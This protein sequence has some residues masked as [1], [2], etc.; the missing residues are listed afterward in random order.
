MSF[1]CNNFFCGLEFYFITKTLVKAQHKILVERIRTF[2]GIVSKNLSENTTHIICPR[3][4]TYKTA[5][6]A[7]NI[8]M[9][10]K[11]TVP[12]QFVNID[13]LPACIAQKKLVP[14]TDFEV[15]S[16]F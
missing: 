11:D 9:R 14:T 13:W 4:M 15:S 16:I 8:S 12:F 1:I 3:G 7:L 2:D 5:L 6:T 10:L